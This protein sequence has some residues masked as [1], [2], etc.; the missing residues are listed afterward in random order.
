V[1]TNLELRETKGRSKVVTTVI[2]PLSGLFDLELIEVWQYWE[3][4][5]FLIWREIKVRYKQTIIGASWAIV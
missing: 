5:Y 1:R 2:Q 4:L 3:L